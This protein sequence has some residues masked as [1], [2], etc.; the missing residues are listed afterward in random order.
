MT[1]ARTFELKAYV[2]LL[3]WRHTNIFHR[4]ICVQRESIIAAGEL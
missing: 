4:L 1:F 2:G 3:K